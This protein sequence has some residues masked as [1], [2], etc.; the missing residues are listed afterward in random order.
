MK[1]A[2]DIVK[3]YFQEILSGKTGETIKLFSSWKS[4]VNDMFSIN[5]SELAK[6]SRIVDIKDGILTIEADH[7]G[8][9]F[10]LKTKTEEILTYYQN[11][12]PDFEI[13]KNKFQLSKNR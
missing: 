11:R 7:P 8:W 12:F 9:V 4:I 5:G 13:E 3:E 2:G 1:T 10:T 6:H